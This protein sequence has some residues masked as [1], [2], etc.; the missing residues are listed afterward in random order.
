[1]KKEAEPKKDI[2][3]LNKHW[4][5]EYTQADMDAPELAQRQFD[6]MPAKK[7]ERMYDKVNETDY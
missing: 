4:V 3:D 1:V 5:M 7:R 2:G 6:P